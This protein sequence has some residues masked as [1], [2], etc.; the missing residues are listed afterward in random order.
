MP[1]V[2]VPKRTSRIEVLLSF[3]IPNPGTF[4]FGNYQRS[5]VGNC[6]HVGETVPESV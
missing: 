2:H 5:I 6:I 1:D 3:F 4:T